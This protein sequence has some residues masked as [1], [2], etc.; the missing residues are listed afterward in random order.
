MAEIKKL[1][2]IKSNLIVYCSDVAVHSFCNVHVH[3]L[4]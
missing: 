2:I 4:A 1:K 3:G